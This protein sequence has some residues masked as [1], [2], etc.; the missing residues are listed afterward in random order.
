[1][2]D[3]GEEGGAVGGG[4]EEVGAR[5]D[6][7]NEILRKNGVSLSFYYLLSTI[8]NTLSTILCPIYY[9]LSTIYPTI[10]YLLC[11]IYYVL[12]TILYYAL[13]TIYYPYY[14][15]YYLLSTI[16]PTIDP[17]MYY[18]LSTVPTFLSL[19]PNDKF[20]FLHYPRGHTCLTM[21]RSS[22]YSCSV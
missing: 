15:L 9:L 22:R 21:L 18:L 1:M 10:Y 4:G 5:L 17:T 3:E 6:R 19:L 20:P 14:L 11:T 7:F 13:Y 8:H 2:E 12:C 16:V